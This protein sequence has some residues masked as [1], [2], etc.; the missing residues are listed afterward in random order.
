MFNTLPRSNAPD[1]DFG[2]KN[3]NMRIPLKAAPEGVKNTDKAGSKTLSLIEFAEH[4]KDD[5]ADRMKETVE[6]RTISTEED[7]KFL[8]DSK[9]TMSMNTL[10]DF[11]RHGSG[12]LNGIEITAGRAETAFAA[13]RDEFE[14]TARR[15]PVHS[16]AVSR[17]PAMNHLLNAFENNGASLKGVLDFF[18]MV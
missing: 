18:I 2:D 14:R 8:R 16:S 3:V 13:K 11:E 12:T 4:T 10:D 6:Q 7:T 1:S 15:T 5:V 9:N 17:I